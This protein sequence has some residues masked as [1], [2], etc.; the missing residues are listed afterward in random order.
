MSM[1]YDIEYYFVVGTWMGLM[2]A[3]GS[4]S[5]IIGKLLALTVD[6]QAFHLLNSNFLEISQRLIM[7]NK[8]FP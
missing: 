3:A 1:R 8:G 7:L 4:M 5:R 2:L 6:L